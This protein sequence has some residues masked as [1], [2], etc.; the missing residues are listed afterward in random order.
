MAKPPSS[1]AAAAA[2]G[3]ALAHHRT[4]LLLL[5]AVAASASTAGFL[6]RGALSDPCDAR[7]NSAASAAGSPLGFMSS[8]LV[9]LVSHELSLSGNLLTEHL[10][11]HTWRTSVMCVLVR[12]NVDRSRY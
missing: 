8:K 3:R 5:V 6:L 4:R 1:A 2:G 10:V 11:A 7:G 9:L 12:E